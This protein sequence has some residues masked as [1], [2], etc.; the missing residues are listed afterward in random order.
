MPPRQGLAGSKYSTMGP[1]PSSLLAPEHWLPL[2]LEGGEGL[3]TVL[4]GDH[5]DTRL[6]QRARAEGQGTGYMAC[7]TVESPGR[8]TPL[9]SRVQT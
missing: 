3:D 8:S 5:L 4:G 9:Q 6:G 2:L 1:S 7:G